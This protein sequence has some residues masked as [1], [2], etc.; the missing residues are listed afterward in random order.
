MWQQ[1]DAETNVAAKTG[2][3]VNQTGNDLASEKDKQEFMLG[4]VEN[5]FKIKGNK[6]VTLYTQSDQQKRVV[7]LDCTKIQFKDF[8]SNDINTAIDTLMQDIKTQSDTCLQ[9][10]TD[11]GSLKA[12]VKYGSDQKYREYE[13][14]SVIWGLS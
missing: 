5:E 2:V 6:N 1:K 3:C 9:K 14:L 7:N 10:A 11:E 4:T 8:S 12:T 13:I